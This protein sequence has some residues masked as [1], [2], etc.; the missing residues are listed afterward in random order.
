MTAKRR[1]APAQKAPANPVKQSDSDAFTLYVRE[2][3]DR[4]NLNDWR[5]EKSSKPAAKA[6]MAEVVRTSLP[7]RLAV[8]RIGT[9]FGSI[10]VTAQSVE[11][12]ACHE[13]LHV[14]LHEYKEF[15]RAGAGEEDIMSAEHRI[16]NTLVGLL[17]ER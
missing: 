17:V 1:P 7:D 4:L 5:I 13:V 10:P 2:W 6:N 8:Y 3:Q 11:A 12:I 9:D 16:V 14:F 15:I